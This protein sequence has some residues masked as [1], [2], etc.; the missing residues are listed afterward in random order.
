MD[1]NE[2]TR[3]KIQQDIQAIEA[4]VSRIED[5]VGLLTNIFEEILKEFEKIK[6]DIADQNKKNKN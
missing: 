2:E 1:S 4:K 5:N 6:K 3:K